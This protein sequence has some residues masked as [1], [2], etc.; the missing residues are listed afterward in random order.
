[1]L[2]A[3]P[4]WIAASAAEGNGRLAPRQ[5]ARALTETDASAEELALALL[6]EAAARAH[7]PVSGYAVGAVAHFALA[8]G[9]EALALGANFEGAGASLHGAVHAEQAAVQCARRHGA[10]RLIALTLSAA[11][12]GHC[13]QFLQ[14]LAGAGELRLR[15]GEREG[16][17]LAALLPHSF[18]PSDLG[19][20]ARL[21]E[22]ASLPLRLLD[23]SS[24]SLVRDAFEA[25]RSAYAPYSRCPAGAALRSRDGAVFT[26]SALESAAFNPSLGAMAAALSSLAM[27]RPA[28]A[29]FAAPAR[30]VLVEAAGLASQRLQAEALLGALAPGLALEY[31]AAR[32]A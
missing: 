28:G 3:L 23:D 32:L 17:T 24:D 4:A 26:G 29:P 10:R 27:A 2:R 22:P 11:P 16:G 25:A 19:R 1:M 5:L 8:D 30:A 13:R 20:E 31:H 18:G 21:L 6:P 14:E 7:A 9:G 12:C 15:W